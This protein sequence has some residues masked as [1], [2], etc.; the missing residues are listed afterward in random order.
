MEIF[1]FIASPL[2]RLNQKN[3][4][5]LWSNACEGILEKLKDKLTFIRILTILEGT[6]RFVMY[7]DIS[8]M[9]MGC[10]YM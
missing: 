9:G 4:M 6:D 8:R 5:F 10:V 3:V 1:S 7:S 2:T